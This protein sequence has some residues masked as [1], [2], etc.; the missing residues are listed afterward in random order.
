MGGAV[1]LLKLR[2]Y[3][4]LLL[5]YGA[6]VGAIAAGNF[7]TL[8]AVLTKPKVGNGSSTSGPICLEVFPSAVMETEIGRLLPGLDRHH[9]PVSD[10]L[11]E[12][13]R[14][15]LRPFLPR[16]EDYQGA[17]DRFEY[18]LGLIHADLTRYETE[19]G[20]WGPVGCFGW[21]GRRYSQESSVSNKISAEMEASGSDWGPLKAGL[22]GGSIE[23]AMI[24]KQK[25]DGFLAMAEWR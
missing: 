4:A 24:A 2:R 5:L 7:S 25:F 22:F 3:P 23:Q 11:F 19:H 14:E 13:L 10:H 8:G 16:D 21:R 20:W 18:F 6:G 17:F 15:P 1:Y 9:T 12:R